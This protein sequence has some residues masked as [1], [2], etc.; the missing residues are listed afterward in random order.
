MV[1]RDL[2]YLSIRIYGPKFLGK[3]ITV[4]HLKAYSHCSLVC[5]SNLKAHSRLNIS[6]LVDILTYK[7]VA[8]S[9]LG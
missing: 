6:N 8:G 2:I 7:I 4:Y 1:V 3:L 9:K 5:E